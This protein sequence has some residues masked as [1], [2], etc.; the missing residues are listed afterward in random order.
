MHYILLLLFVFS[1]ICSLIF[2]VIWARMLAPVFGNTVYAATI[3]ITT[4]M[5]GLAIG[6]FAGGR[7]AEKSKN[8]LV[9]FTVSQFLIGIYAFLA[10]FFISL[11]KT[12]YIYLVGQ[13]EYS[14]FYLNSIRSLLSF[15]V[16]LFPATCM[17]IVIPALAE[18]ISQKS[19]RGKWAISSVYS[20]SSF[21]GAAGCFLAGFF[22]ITK[23]GISGS[24]YLSGGISVLVSVAVFFLWRY[25]TNTMTAG[26]SQQGV[27]EKGKPSV[28]EILNFDDAI[29]TPTAYALI[30]LAFISGLTSL[31][32]EILY[33][34][35]LIPVIESTTYSFSLIL[36]VFLFG[37]GFGNYLCFKLLKSGKKLPVYAVI[38]EIAVGVYSICLIVIFPYLFDLGRVLYNATGSLTWEK[39]VLINF[40][41][42]LSV[43]AIP[44][45]LFGMLLP[46]LS[47]V[48]SSYINKI[49]KGVGDTFYTNTAGSIIGCAFTGFFLIPYFGVKE[50]LIIF[51]IIN[52]SA[53]LLLFIINNLSVRAIGISLISLTGI[54]FIIPGISK[55]NFLEPMEG[56]KIVYYKEGIGGNVEVSQNVRGFNILRVDN[57]T[58]GSNEPWVKVDEVRIAHFPLFLHN[59]P[60]DVLL[61]GLGT[62]I[63]LDAVVR[64]SINTV[65]CVEI[66]GELKNTIS[67]FF[68]GIPKI[69]EREDVRIIIEDGRNYILR[70]KKKYDVVIM[71]LIHP[72]SAGAGSLFTKEYYEDAGKI[73][74]GNG[75][76]AQWLP[77][78]QL[79]NLELKIIIHTFAY[80]FSY[81]SLWFGSHNQDFPLVLLLGSNDELSFDKKKI[82]SRLESSELSGELTEK[83]DVN[84]LLDNFIMD[85]KGL[86]EYTNGV[87][88]NT[89]DYPVIEFLVPK[90]LLQRNQYGR[91]NYY[92]LKRLKQRSDNFE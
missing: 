59:N 20:I 80:V 51:G 26:H 90:W 44:T 40:I 7:Y 31:G 5:A 81:S 29:E 41:L 63:T 21:G 27:G 89:E 10:P 37:L 85:K 1:S 60:K 15:L 2:E 66:V 22:L 92:N 64:H 39:T 43:L 13:N 56:E 82:K 53:G 75:L 61:I 25:D 69:M 65:D 50:S 23:L 88:L 49:G 77:L 32:Y 30:V 58:H 24:N 57:K 84:Q 14:L 11:I 18:E 78:Y 34:R 33:L 83:N 8:P 73:I 86:L 71:D 6:G 91:E 38:L 87:S 70:A 19:C 46:L 79:S 28:R 47:T 4:F 17:C 42:T 48:F 16:I 62:G 9:L 67:Y 35:L 3:V 74:K 76:V 54:F 45:T 12:I 52:V 55:I 68:D 72:E 36:S